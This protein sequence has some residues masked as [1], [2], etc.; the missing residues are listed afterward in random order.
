VT[1]LPASNMQRT[2]IDFEQALAQVL[3]DRYALPD[4]GPVTATVWARASI[5]AIRT[6]LGVL[7][8]ASAAYL[9]RG[10]PRWWLRSSR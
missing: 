7:A 4:T 10:R 3:H 8:G 9:G 5:G 6:A 1:D 2:L